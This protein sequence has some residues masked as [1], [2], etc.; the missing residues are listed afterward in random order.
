VSSGERSANGG[1]PPEAEAAA[2]NGRGVGHVELKEE[3]QRA[4][5]REEGEAKVVEGEVLEG[6]EGVGLGEVVELCEGEGRV[7]V[8]DEGWRSCGR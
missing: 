2:I 4:D 3:P 7:G 6:A 1:V 8:G 5:L